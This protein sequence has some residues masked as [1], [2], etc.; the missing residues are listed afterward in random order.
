MRRLPRHLIIAF[1]AAWVP[2]LFLPFAQGMIKAL[3]GIELQAM[4]VSFTLWFL[5]S[6][7]IR[8]SKLSLW[9]IA[10]FVSPFIGLPLVC[11]LATDSGIRSGSVQPEAVH[12]ANL[13]GTFISKLLFG[14]ISAVFLSWI[15][16]PVGLL[17]GL[18]GHGVSRIFR[19]YEGTTA[20]AARNLTKPEE[21]EGAP[22]SATRSE[23]DFPT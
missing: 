11:S 8:R 17:M 22:Q 21:T 12:N 16:I 19:G 23:F 3:Q 5:I 4:L 10:G 18:I 6:L 14:F 9:L 7:F 15:F 20:S 13:V 2:I 1:I